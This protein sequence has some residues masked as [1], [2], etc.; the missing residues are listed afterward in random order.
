LTA[1]RNLIVVDTNIL[2]SAGIF[3]G[4]IPYQAL[5]R[6]FEKGDVLSSPATLAEAREVMAREKFDRYVPYGLRMLRLETI[7]DQMKSAEPVVCDSGCRDPK[8]EK[9]LD[10]AFGAGASLILSGDVHLLELHPFRGI[11]ILSPLEY[12][13]QEHQ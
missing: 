11:S 3:P 13:A 4:S 12:M 9:F 6:A 8:D 1:T 2:I 5:I 10:L 7:L